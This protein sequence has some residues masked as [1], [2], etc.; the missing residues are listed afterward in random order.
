MGVDDDKTTHPLTPRNALR[1]IEV[2]HD[3]VS[4]LRPLQLHDPECLPILRQA[5]LDILEIQAAMIRGIRD[6]GGLLDHQCVIPDALMALRATK[7]DT[8]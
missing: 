7:E 1:L 3:H 2:A 5:I 4:S 6:H 8:P